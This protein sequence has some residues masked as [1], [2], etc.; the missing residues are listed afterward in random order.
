[1]RMR[2]VLLSEISKIFTVIGVDFTWVPTIWTDDIE[3]S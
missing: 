1:M 3:N 2:G